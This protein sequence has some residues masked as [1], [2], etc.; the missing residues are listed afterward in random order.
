MTLNKALDLF[1]ITDISVESESELKLKFKKLTKK[2]HPDNIKTG[3]HAKFLDIHDAFEM[4]KDAIIKLNQYKQLNTN[5]QL[6]TMVIPLDKLVYLYEGNKFT[7]GNGDNTIEVDKKTMSKNNS[8][9]LSKV[10]IIHNG[11]E[12]EFTNIERWDISD[13]YKVY[14]TVDVTD[15]N[16]KESVTVKIMDKVKEFDMEYQ[17]ITLRFTLQFNIVVDVI[18]NKKIV[19]ESET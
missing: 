18:L 8:L 16:S 15:I 17:S 7:M 4:L 3:D 9:I 5:K 12:K 14:C 1:E 10:N 2:Y 11:L 6:I 13:R 19:V